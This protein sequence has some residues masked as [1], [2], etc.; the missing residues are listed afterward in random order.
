MIVISLSMTMMTRLMLNLRDTSRI[1]PE[2]RLF[3][4][5]SS[6]GLA[7]AENPSNAEIELGT[8]S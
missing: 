1:T 5:R 3:P 8:M 4:G 7:F 6:T 2:T